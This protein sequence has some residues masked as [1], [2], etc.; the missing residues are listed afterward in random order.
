MSTYLNADC[1]AMVKTTTST[2]WPSLSELMLHV[3]VLIM[4][5]TV[6]SP[7]DLNPIALPRALSTRVTGLLVADLPVNVSETVSLF[8]R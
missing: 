4:A 8:H 7:P 3:A 5:D 6:Q 2:V 1:T